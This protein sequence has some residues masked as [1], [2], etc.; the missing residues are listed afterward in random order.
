M[1]WIKLSCKLFIFGV[2]SA[3]IILIGLYVY[4]YFAPALDIKNANQFLIYDDKE[5]LIYQGSSSN[6]WVNIEDISQDVIDAVISVE[7]KN[8]YSHHGFDYLRIV[9]A[10]YL[11]FKNNGIVQG[12]S[13]ISQQYVKNLYLEFDKTWERKIEE[14]LLTMKLEQFNT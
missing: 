14:A 7:D 12:A 10:L 6:S 1:K 11:N 13:T 3:F 9:K 8:F 2:I 5:E 4:A